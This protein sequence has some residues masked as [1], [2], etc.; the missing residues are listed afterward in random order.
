VISNSSSGITP[1]LFVVAQL[2]AAAIIKNAI[3]SIKA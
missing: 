2:E 1:E 3:N